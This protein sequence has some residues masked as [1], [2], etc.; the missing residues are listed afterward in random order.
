MT[1]YTDPCTLPEINNTIGCPA[2]LTGNGA[3]CTLQCAAGFQP[4]PGSV[5]TS[6]IVSCTA[7][8][9]VNFPDAGSMSPGREASYT[10][11]YAGLG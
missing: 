6:F 8:D 4:G 10:P 5:D 11:T 3:N 2:S 9:L 7:G 1:V